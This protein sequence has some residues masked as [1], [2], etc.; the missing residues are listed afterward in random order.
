MKPADL[1]NVEMMLASASLVLAAL[2]F[3]LPIFGVT[4]SSGQDLSTGQ[5]M[6]DMKE[7][8]YFDVRDVTTTTSTFT[9]K[10][11]Y[12]YD[13]AGTPG[14][15]DVGHAFAQEKLWIAAW[16]V[17]CWL[18]LVSMV[19]R[20]ALA[21]IVFGWGTVIASL[22]SVAYPISFVSATIPGVTGFFGSSQ[23]QLTSMGWG[24]ATGWFVALAGCVLVTAVV[25]HRMGEYFK[26]W[27]RKKEEDKD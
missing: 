24:P 19:L 25:M 4:S 5:P 27:P 18:L 10:T 3:M 12:S 26:E 16:L 1:A 11:T 6:H 20:S 2:T 14:Y 23:Q 22:I 9:S 17:L 15:S 21:Q 8:F 13:Y 7:A